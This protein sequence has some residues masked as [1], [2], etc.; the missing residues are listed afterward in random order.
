M[1]DLLGL[2]DP[3]YYRNRSLQSSN[4]CHGTKRQRHTC[5]MYEW[6]IAVCIE[7]HNKS[8]KGTKS[9]NDINM[10]KTLT[11]EQSSIHIIC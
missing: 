8:T 5:T 10:F 9:E 6:F 3:D 7:V 2:G 11:S 4:Y 1:M